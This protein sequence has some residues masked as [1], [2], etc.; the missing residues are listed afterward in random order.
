MRPRRR[1]SPPTYGINRTDSGRFHTAFGHLALQPPGKLRPQRVR[2][3]MGF[4]L[5]RRVLMS[6]A[7]LLTQKLEKVR[8]FGEQE[9]QEAAPFSPQRLVD[10][11]KDQ[12]VRNSLL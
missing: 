4:V 11:Q 9:S 8:L 6:L 2:A 7:V 1:I 5:I 10:A 3:R 12:V